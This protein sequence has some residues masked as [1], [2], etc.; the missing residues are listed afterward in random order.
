VGTIESTGL[1]FPRGCDGAITSPQPA[2]DSPVM[3]QTQN[4]EDS[5][6]LVRRGIALEWTTLGWNVI[7]VGIL[8]FLALSASSVALAGF[9]LDS[10]I[11][12]AAS[13]VVIWELS[14]SGPER[15]RWALRIMGIAFVALAAYL[16]AQ[17]TV[18]LVVQHH[19]TPS[20]WG[21]L[22]TGVTA[23]VMFALAFGKRRTGEALGNPVLV[24][25]GRVTFVD[26][27]LAVAVL[28]GVA[29][30]LLFDWWWADAVA[31][32]V[33]FFYAIREAVH[34]FR[35]LHADRSTRELHVT[36]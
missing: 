32:Y 6:A 9:G 21:I 33:L 2:H 4:V 26:G 36:L 18:S 12:I 23:I 14:G 20:L 10:L 13:A 17:S 3:H 35:A 31:S 11:E 7:G 16:F 27:M 34:V 28:L 22:W 8:A 30:D 25:E 15:R 1:D 24:T 29:L 19:P 5:E